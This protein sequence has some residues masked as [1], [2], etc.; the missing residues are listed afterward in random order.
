MQALEY[1]FNPQ[2]H[3]YLK[4]FEFRPEKKEVFHLGHLFLIVEFTNILKEDKNFIKELAEFFK[5]T[6]YSEKKSLPEKALI[7]TLKKVNQKFYKKTKKGDI[8]WVGNLNIAVLVSANYFLYFSRGG[9]IQILLLRGDELSDIAQDL[10][11]K[12]TPSPFRF[13]GG[14]ASGKLLSGDKVMVITQKLF[15]DIYDEI[16][17]ELINLE[18]IKDKTLK[19]FFKSKK[20]EVKNSSG[21]FFLLSVEEKIPFFS[22]K[23]RVPKINKTLFLVL[24]LLALLVISYFIFR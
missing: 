13:L 10:E 5:K 6:Y 4:V 14:V 1:Y 24:S 11:E 19:K 16:L 22:F 20:K 3:T 12:T 15:E 7:E 9:S 23:F 8:R 2:K 21:I 18:E 17:P